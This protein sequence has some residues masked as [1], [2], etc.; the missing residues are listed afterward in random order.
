M[1]QSCRRRT[2]EAPAP[3][4]SFLPILLQESNPFSPGLPQAVAMFHRNPNPV[5]GYDVGR[6]IKG[7]VVVIEVVTRGMGLRVGDCD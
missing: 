3:L 4:Q 6:T 2:A 1:C 7:Q 5:A